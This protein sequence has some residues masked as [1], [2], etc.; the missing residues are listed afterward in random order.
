ML[1]QTS[2]IG[3]NPAVSIPSQD[4]EKALQ[5]FPDKLQKHFA[6]MPT[7]LVQDL[8]EDAHAGANSS[9]INRTAPQ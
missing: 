4:L 3:V 7:A 2:P 5:P 1:S 9:G 6:D 8:I